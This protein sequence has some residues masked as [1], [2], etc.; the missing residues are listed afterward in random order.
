MVGKYEELLTIQQ[1]ETREAYK[2][3]ENAENKEK[4]NIERYKQDIEQVIVER[5]HYK[6]DADSI[7]NEYENLKVEKEH[8]RKELSK[9]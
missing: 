3:I 1:N 2:E 9:F 6:N 5:N 4:Q 8:L 7:R